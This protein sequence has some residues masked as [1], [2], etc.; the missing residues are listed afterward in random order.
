MHHVIH[1]AVDA[2][3]HVADS[4]DI[5]CAKVSGI[6]QFDKLICIDQNPIG[7]TV[8]ADVVTYIDVLTPIREFFSSLPLSR[9]KGLE[10]KHFSYNHRKGMCT[11]CQG[12]GYKKI[13]MQFLPAVTVVCDQCHGLR[14]NPTSLEV[15]YQEKNLGQ[16]LQMTVEE[17]RALFTNHPRVVRLLDTL[18]SV[19]LGYLQLGQEIAT[20]SGGEAQRMKLS[21]ELAKRSTGRTLYLLDEP[22]TGLHSDDISK[23]LSVLHRLVDKGNTMIIIE[24]HLDMIRNADYVVDLGPEAGEDGGQVVCAGTPEQIMKN[25]RSHTGRYLC[26]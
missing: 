3:L 6:S 17:A 19:G 15:F 10:P 8:R 20:L 1:P 2:G 14:L 13:E 26:T 23:L 18:I 9:S 21:R 5:G 24:H 4:V 12:L 7:H 11:S 16:I 25:K 22:T